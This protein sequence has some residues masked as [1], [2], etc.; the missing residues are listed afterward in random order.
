[1]KWVVWASLIG[2]GFVLH[3]ALDTRSLVWAVAA[4]VVLILL[5]P[6]GR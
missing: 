2:C 4:G 5:S 6:A 3:L 1:M